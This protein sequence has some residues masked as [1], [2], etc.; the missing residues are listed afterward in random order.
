MP[1]SVAATVLLAAEYGLEMVVPA[2]AEGEQLDLVDVRFCDYEGGSMAHLL[3]EVEGQPVSFSVILGVHHAE[4]S[5]E[6]MGLAARLWSNDAS[7]CVFVG[8]EDAARMDKL[9]TYMRGYER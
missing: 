5:L 7:T 3:Y 8:H 6:V 2:S 4:R 9:A 1:L